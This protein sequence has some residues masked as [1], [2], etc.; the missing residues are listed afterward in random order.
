[1]EVEDAGSAKTGEQDRLNA[2]DASIA[3]LEKARGGKPD[4]AI[5]EVLQQKRLERQEPKDQSQ[6]RKSTKALLRAAT[7][8]REQAVIKLEGFQKEEMDLAQ[9]L[10]LKQ[11]VISDAKSEAADKA[12][13]VETLQARRLAEVDCDES[14]S[15]SPLL[16]LA[17]RHCHLSSGRLDLRR[18]SRRRSSQ[19]R[20]VVQQRRDRGQGV[21]GSIFG[22]SEP[23]VSSHVASSG[24]CFI[25]T[26]CGDIYGVRLPCGQGSFPLPACRAACCV[27]S[28]EQESGAAAGSRTDRECRRQAIAG[29]R[30]FKDEVG[31]ARRGRRVLRPAQ[32]SRTLSFAR[33]QIFHEEFLLMSCAVAGSRRGCN[34][35]FGKRF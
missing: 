35:R 30:R 21:S 20:G 29:C 6:S 14:V 17:P 13:E 28:G 23:V 15:Q 5:D 27:V 26:H 12:R 32:R 18:C 1:M 8:A 24:S 16:H 11:Q 10:L 34:L 25:D 2:L 19:V 22:G 4:V 3:N 31:S 33:W 7:A 9:L